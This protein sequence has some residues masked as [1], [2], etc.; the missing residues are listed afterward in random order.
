MPHLF[1]RGSP[2]T[3]AFQCHWDR[4]ELSNRSAV[5]PPPPFVKY[6]GAAATPPADP[7]STPII[8]PHPQR[9]FRC[10]AKLDWVRFKN[11]GQGGE[12]GHHSNRFPANQQAPNPRNQG[13]RRNPAL[14]VGRGRP[15]GARL[16]PSHSSLSIQGFSQ[17]LPRAVQRGPHVARKRCLRSP[18][19]PIMIGS[20]AASPHLQLSTSSSPRIHLP[21]PSPAGLSPQSA[22]SP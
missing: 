21:S 16:R 12:D 17:R 4:L 13:V 15:G 1:P 19:H 22:P 20:G 6:P 7:N 8:Q 18:K 10:G 14:L 2:A 11:I 9:S 5:V 3:T